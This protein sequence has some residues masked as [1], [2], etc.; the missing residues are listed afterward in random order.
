MIG[1]GRNALITQ[2]IYR[3]FHLVDGG[4]VDDDIPIRVLSQCGHQEIGVLGAATLADQVAE[5]GAMEAGNVFVGI[6]QRELG[7][8]VVPNLTGSAGGEGRYG[9]I[10]KALPQPVQL[11][12]LGTKLVAPLGYAMGFIN[13]EEGNGNVLEPGEGV[14]SLEPLWRQI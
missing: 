4:G 8:N 7:E 1:N 13:G 12:V 14:G 10:W 6:A 11:A 3:L 9:A 2:E 5:V